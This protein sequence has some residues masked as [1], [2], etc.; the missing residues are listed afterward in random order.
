MSV[1]V[2]PLTGL[3]FKTL[4][5]RRSDAEETDLQTFRDHETDSIEHDMSSKDTIQ[6]DNQPKAR[7]LNYSALKE[8]HKTRIVPDL[9][10]EDIEETFVRGA[11][12]S[13]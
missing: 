2:L 10:E 6:H 11:K 4:I 12:P 9:L 1:V 13:R 3:T 8:A 5:G 7:K